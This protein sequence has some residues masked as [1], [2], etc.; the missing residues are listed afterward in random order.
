MLLPY[1]LPTIEEDLSAI[2]GRS[3]CE[4][5]PVG[6]A[7][8]FLD[9]FVEHPAVFISCIE[10]QTGIPDHLLR[11]KTPDIYGAAR[12]MITPLRPTALLIDFLTPISA[13]D[14]HGDLRGS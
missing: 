9:Q 3:Y 7:A 12:Q 8:L 11:P 10:Q 13:V 14:N 1:Y 6:R 5:D 4:M 2:V